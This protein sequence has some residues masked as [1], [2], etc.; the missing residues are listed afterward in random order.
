MGKDNC[1]YCSEEV[2]TYKFYW[3]GKYF[4]SKQCMQDYIADYAEEEY[5]KIVEAQNGK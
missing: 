5:K 1:G 4:C 3:D 2:T